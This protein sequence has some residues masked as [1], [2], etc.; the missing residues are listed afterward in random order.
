VADEIM[1]DF[2]R[3][4]IQTWASTSVFF[5]GDLVQNCTKFFGLAQINSKILDEIANKLQIKKNIG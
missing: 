3:K 1:K 2:V 5:S 4:S